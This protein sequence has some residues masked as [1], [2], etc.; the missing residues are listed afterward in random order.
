MSYLI[1]IS[2]VIYDLNRLYKSEKNS[3]TLSTFSKEQALRT[4][5]LVFLPYKFTEGNG[6]YRENT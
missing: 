2:G 5:I 6:Q 1:R 4:D 3:G